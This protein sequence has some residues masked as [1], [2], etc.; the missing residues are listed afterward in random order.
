MIALKGRHISKCPRKKYFTC[1]TALK[2]WR[3]PTQLI[4]ITALKNW[5][6]PTQLIIFLDFW[7]RNI[8]NCLGTLCPPSKF[9][10]FTSMECVLLFFEFR[11]KIFEFLRQVFE[12]RVKIF[13]FRVKIFE[14]RVKISWV[15]SQVSEFRAK[16]L[17]FEPSFR[18]SASFLSFEA[19]FPVK[20]TFFESKF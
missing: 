15:S 4:I 18:V 20:L 16:F 17:S 8:K 11:V 9:F 2:N 5:R 13:E 6:F 7:G 3:F 19:E 14:F 10:L 12:F 1:I